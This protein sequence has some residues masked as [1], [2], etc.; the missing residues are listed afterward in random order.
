MVLK[1]G[2]LD[3][4]ESSHL[5]RVAKDLLSSDQ[6]SCTGIEE[7]GK[8]ASSPS[9]AFSPQN[10]LPIL[11]GEGFRFTQVRFVTPRP[12]FRIISFFGGNDSTSKPVIDDC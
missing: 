3:T 12:R 2:M 6:T 1:L 4:L 9:I 5:E 11:I 7:N 10:V 8:C